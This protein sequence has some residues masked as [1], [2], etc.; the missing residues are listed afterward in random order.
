MLTH[1]ILQIL[2]ARSTLKINGALAPTILIHS[3]KIMWDRTSKTK[4]WPNNQ[5][6]SL[7]F[8]HIRHAYALEFFQ[9]S[10]SYGRI[11]YNIPYHMGRVFSLSSYNIPHCIWPPD[12][13]S[14]LE[15]IAC[16]CF[17]AHIGFHPYLHYLRSIGRAKDTCDWASSY[18]I[19][20]CTG[21][22]SELYICSYLFNL[23]PPTRRAPVPYFE[24][25]FCAACQGIIF[26]VVLINALVM[27]SSL[28]FIAL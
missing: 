15:R 1:V 22:P 24:V 12:R 13:S 8:K 21:I 16:S 6:F 4:F 14:T 18:N 27:D 10:Q 19:P 23:F 11:S 2:W 9:H 20:H 5:T 3:L 26:H 28:S 7:K 17:D 25:I